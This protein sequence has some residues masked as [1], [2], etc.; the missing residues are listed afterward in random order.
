[1]IQRV[2]DFVVTFYLWHTKLMRKREG[3][4]GRSKW[5]IDSV[6]QI[7]EVFGHSP[8]KGVHHKV[9]PFLYH[10]H[11]CNHVRWSRICDGWSTHTLSFWSTWGVA[12]FRPLLVPSLSIG[13]F[14]VFLLS[15]LR[16]VPL[17][18]LFLQV[19]ILFGEMFHYCRKGLDLS[20]QG[21]GSRLVSLNIVGSRH[22]ASKYYAT[23]CPRSN[24]MAYKSLISHRRR[25]LTMPK[26]QQ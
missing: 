5:E 18:Q 4:D 19:M 7:I 26:N 6:D 15:T 20:L 14:L 16:Y 8:S 12:T 2:L 3:I 13:P 22:R 24:S 23:L 9:H 21:N 25:Q 11:L 1:M 10:L 17:P